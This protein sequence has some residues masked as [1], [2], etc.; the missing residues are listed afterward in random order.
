[1]IN[2]LPR[3]DDDR[4]PDSAARRIDAACDHFEAAWRGGQEPRI[5]D[6]L[7][8]AAEAERPALLRELITL[9]IELRRKRGEDPKP[10]EYRDR[11]PGQAAMVDDALTAAALRPECNRPRPTRD[12]TNGHLHFGLLALQVG[13]IDQDQLVAAFGAL[14]RARGK[15]LAEILLERGS[16]DA[17]SRSLLAAMADKR[18]RL[19]G[20]DTKKSLTSLA[21]EPSTLIQL[22]AIGDTDLTGSITQEGSHT[23]TLDATATISVGTTTSEGQRFRVLRPHAHGGLGEVFVALDS[24]LNREVAL[25]QILDHHA[26][27][28]TSRQRFLL[29]A[30]ITGGLEHPGIVPVYG[31]GPTMAAGRSTP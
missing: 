30:Q 23:P 12:D 13:L 6:F 5:E 16:I 28:P 9:E 1:M 27:D 3:A 29:E 2:D 21:A 14:A 17:E 26:D 15:S 4:R 31:V 25:K 7:D 10:G 22:A 18:L 20:G 24:E 19:H 11:F 8:A